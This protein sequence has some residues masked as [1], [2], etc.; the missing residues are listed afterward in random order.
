MNKLPKGIRLDHGYIQ[1][2][3]MN[4]G[5]IYCKNFGLDSSLGRELA[6]I[7]LAEKKKEILM[8]KFGVQQIPQK[9]F[10]EVADIYLALWS[11]EITPDGALKH[12][13]NSVY[14]TKIVIE[15]EFKP[16]FKNY[17]FDE[18][19]PKD[20][21]AWRTHR[22][23]TVLGTTA[24]RNQNILSSIFSHIEQW[25]KTETVKTFKLPSENPCQFVEKSSTRKRERLITQYEISKLKLA[26]KELGDENACD[27][28]SL[29]IKTCLSFNDLESLKF[30]DIVNLNRSKTGVAVNIPITVKHIPNWT[31]WRKRWLDICAKATLTDIEFRDLRK[32]GINILKDR[33]HDMKA[34]SQYAG[35]ASEKTTESFYIKANSE[36]LRV[37]AQDLEIIV[38]SL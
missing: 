24:N 21:D 25:V 19:L 4:K 30:G 1:V 20:V 27:N 37:L 9:K 28:I 5:R 3:I 14:N 18:I 8:G 22:L 36:T 34:V 35:H 17:Y 12:V 23:K 31:N 10:S 33:G 6:Q 16:F 32:A 26:A 2:R 13:E 38:D 29:A 7:H 11:K 15:S